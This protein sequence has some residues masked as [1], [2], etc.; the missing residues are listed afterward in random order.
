MH[1]ADLS[2]SIDCGKVQVIH[3]RKTPRAIRWIYSRLESGGLQQGSE[4]GS[5]R[6]PP[7]CQAPLP[8]ATT[9]KRIELNLSV[10]ILIPSPF[11]SLDL[12]KMLEEMSSRVVYISAL[13]FLGLAQRV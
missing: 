10:H 12:A 13:V 8:Q 1:E 7:P 5:L 4:A 2:V 9:P 6:L 11:R 3:G